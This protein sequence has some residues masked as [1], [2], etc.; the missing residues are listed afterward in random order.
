M[1]SDR[2]RAQH[3]AVC[4]VSNIGDAVLTLPAVRALGEMFTAP[5]TLICSKVAF[6]LCFRE[7]SGRFVDTTGLPLTGPHPRPG[8]GPHR[9]ADYDTLAT[10]IGAVDV[11]IDTLPWS[12]LSSTVV[13]PLVHRLAPTTSIGFPTD[14]RYDVVVAQM[15]C[16]WADLMFKLPLA[17][18]PSVRIEDY[19]QPVPIPALVREQA[20]AIRAAV[21]P[22]S[23]VLVVH[24]DTD[25]T[26][27]R[28]PATRF[29]ALLDR[30]LASHPDYVVWV[31][32]MGH[33]ELN[34]GREGDRVFP[35]LGLP[36]D[37]AMSLV[38]HADLFVGIDSCM[39]HAADLARVP[40]V[41]LF[42]PTRAA[43]WG[44][45]FAPHRHVDMSTM[46]DISVEQVLSAMEELVELHA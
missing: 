2:L 4:F 24:A 42:G 41:G 36:L 11:F 1:L 26:E 3:P 22:G 38:A 8:S 46:A 23:K 34:A 13:R 33:E 28:W 32:G 15:D 10:E 21:T 12:A 29:I 30:F 17:F 37:L 19:A 31:V 27:K 9:P 7:V 20:R 43:T 5:I 25:W 16:H 18:D 35:Y 6:D 40:G 39:L 45:R 14:Y 44:F